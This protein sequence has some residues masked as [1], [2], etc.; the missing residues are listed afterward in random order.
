MLGREIRRFT[1]ILSATASFE[2]TTHA[3]PGLVLCHTIDA[4]QNEAIFPGFGSDRDSFPSRT[5]SLRPC[6]LAPLR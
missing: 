1:G 5:P 2:D 3:I 4:L 6:V